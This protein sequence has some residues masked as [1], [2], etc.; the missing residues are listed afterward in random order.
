MSVKNSAM[1]EMVTIAVIIVSGCYMPSHYFQLFLF[2]CLLNLICC[3]QDHF[4]TVLYIYVFLLFD[5]SHD[6]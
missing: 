2:T 4:P 6:S 1:T 3:L 5:L